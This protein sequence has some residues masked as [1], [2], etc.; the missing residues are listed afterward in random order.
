MGGT[1]SFDDDSSPVM[2]DEKRD[3]LIFI[4]HKNYHSKTTAV[5]IP[6]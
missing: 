3:S 4:T 1:Q 2:Y 6:Q 5:N